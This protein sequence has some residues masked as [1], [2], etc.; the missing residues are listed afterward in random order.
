[1]EQKGN[2][3]EL[4]AYIRHT[5]T[6]EAGHYTCAAKRKHPFENKKIW[7][8]FDDEIATIIDNEQKN[9]DSAYLLFFRRVDMP[10]SAYINFT[11]F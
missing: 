7:V 1:M 3:Y 6:N 2:V 11:D 8:N 9:I 5:G 4:Y 10:N